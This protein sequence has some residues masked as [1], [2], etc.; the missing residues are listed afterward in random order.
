MAWYAAHSIISIRPRKPRT[1]E[2]VVYENVILLEAFDD[3]EA[4][5][6]ARNFGQAS[7]VE[8][9]TLTLNGEPAEQSFVGIRKIIAISNPSPLK[10][11]GD[12]PVDGTE[13]T[14][15]EFAVKDDK[16]LA[17]LVK[18]DGIVVRYIE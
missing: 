12:R 9:Q 10:Q 13:I 4:T 8:D 14:Y 17:K 5:T 15:S 3:E 2:I 11:D 16:A 6:K 1:G 7:V 18:G